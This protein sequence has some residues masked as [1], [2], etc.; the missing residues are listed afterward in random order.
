MSWD[1]VSTK[2]W[3]RTPQRPQYT[4]GKIPL[5]VV[6]LLYEP[7][8]RESCVR[9]SYAKNCSPSCFAAV[10]SASMVD[11]CSCGVL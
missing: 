3:N 8:C 4:L 1:M 5:Q 2:S 9:D 6:F 11:A 7:S 10:L